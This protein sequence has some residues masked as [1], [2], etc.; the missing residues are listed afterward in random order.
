MCN[1]FTICSASSA[2]SGLSANKRQDTGRLVSA[3]ATGRCQQLPVHLF[4]D[5][6]CAEQDTQAGLPNKH[7][8][9][10]STRLGTSASPLLA[11][12]LCRILSIAPWMALGAS[13]LRLSQSS[14]LFSGTGSLSS[15][16]RSREPL[17]SGVTLLSDETLM[18]SMSVG[19]VGGLIVIPP[20]DLPAGTA[21]AR[22]Q[23]LTGRLNYSHDVAFQRHCTVLRSGWSQQSGPP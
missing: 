10:D 13:A 4:R 2:S 12:V 23:R 22:Q 5:L 7:A 8:K 18:S 9:P 14:V 1:F 11:R 6:C 17:S 15:Q 20:R 21:K 3:L 19:A 16:R